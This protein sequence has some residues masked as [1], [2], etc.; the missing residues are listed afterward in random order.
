MTI[1]EVSLPKVFALITSAL[2]VVG[3]GTSNSASAS[4]CLPTPSLDSNHLVESKTLSSG[5]Q[6]L[7]W[8]WNPGGDAS[9]ASL[10]PLGTRVSIATGNL[11]KVSFGILHWQ[12]PQTQ[13]LRMLSY[14]DEKS[15]ASLNGDYFDGN[16]PWNAMLED[17]KMIYSPPIKTQVVGLVQARIDST[18]GYRGTGTLTLAGKKYLV[19]G[20]NQLNPGPDSIVVY[21]QKFVQDLTP[22]GQLTL[23]LKNGKVFKIYSKGAL[24]SKRLGTVVQIR[25]KYVP[26]LAKLVVKKPAR[27]SLGAAPKFETRMTSDSVAPA[28]SVSSTNNTIPIAAYNFGDLSSSGATLFDGNYSET[29]RSGRV[30]LRITPDELGR[31]IVR[32]VYRQGY[33]T[34]VDE[35]GFIVQANGLS[36][37]AALKFKVGDVVNVSMGYRAASGA[38]F[39]NAAGRGPVLVKNGKVVWICA[40]H[41]KEFRPRS[42]IGWN[43][44]GQVWLMASSRGVDAADF[45]ARQGG[46]T[47]DQMGRWLLSLG[48]TDAVL[49]DGG[50]STTMEVRDPITSWKRFDLPDSAWYRALANGFSLESKN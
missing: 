50:G 36:A 47:A 26:L 45:G 12:V 11:R 6:A 42:A 21:G 40:M 9:A 15:I 16:G 17:G 37:T 4:S 13:D 14:T 7:A 20:V 49:L 2:L 1:S 32:N 41:T 31:Q 39:I 24:I 25:G 22:K 8:Q 29:T 44:D 35:G 10:S 28:G 23:V 30:T 48:A 46:S 3:L 5:V 27:L 43:K 34:R 18:K 33:F 38:N 19:T